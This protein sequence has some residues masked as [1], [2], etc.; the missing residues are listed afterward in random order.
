MTGKQKL[1][2]KAWYDHKTPSRKGSEGIQISARTNIQRENNLFFA[3]KTKVSLN[4][5]C[6]MGGEHDIIGPSRGKE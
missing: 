5:G 1:I 6:G 3:Q 4:S 2:Q